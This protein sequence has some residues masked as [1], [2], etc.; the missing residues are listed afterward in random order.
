[1]RGFC[2][3]LTDMMSWGEVLMKNK[4]KSSV[5]IIGGADGTTSIF[6]AGKMDRQPLKIKIWNAIYQYKR[7][8]AAKKI[9]VGT[10]TL[11][12]TVKYARKT[13]GM[14]ELSTDTS[15]YQ[16]LKRNLKES[17]MWR[18][19]KDQEISMDFHVYELK[20]VDGCLE[21]EID[22]NWKEFT[23]SYSGRKK[24]AKQFRKISQEL[25]RYYGVS[26]QDIKEMSERYHTLLAALSM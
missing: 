11:E 19:K 13:Y 1:M 16:D 5:T 14:T 8:Q 21:M 3:I 24:V 25:Y 20:T 23:I 2:V 10:H 26:E 22:Y 7:R 17:L 6:I 4:K 15:K 18:Q 12:E 9:V